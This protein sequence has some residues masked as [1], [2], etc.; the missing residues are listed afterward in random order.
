MSPFLQSEVFFP[1]AVP[2]TR[3]RRLP[4]TTGWRVVLLSVCYLASWLTTASAWAHDARADSSVATSLT[5]LARWQRQAVR[6][7][8]LDTRHRRDLDLRLRLSALLPQL[9]ATYGRGT[10]F[11]YSTRTDGFSDLIPDGDRSSYS[12]SLSWDLGRLLW[13]HEELTLYRLT[14]QLASERR[15]LLLEVASL[16]LRLCQLRRRQEP[17]APGNNGAANQRAVGAQIALQAALGEE[18]SARNAPHCPEPL[19]D[20]ASLVESEPTHQGASGPH[21]RRVPT[22]TAQDPQPDEVP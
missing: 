8:G 3:A 16:Y 2:P 18:A 9:R 6:Q 13:N 4:P 14:P 22:E 5:D 10:Q 1:F 7:A 12:V 21:R 11:A 17:G 20:A 15:Q 19:P